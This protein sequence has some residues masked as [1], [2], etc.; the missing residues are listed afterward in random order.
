[1]ANNKDTIK[2]QEAQPIPKKIEGPGVKDDYVTREEAVVK[3]YFEEQMGWLKERI[4][5]TNYVMGVIV[6]VL[7]IG[8]ITLLITVIG[9]VIQA[10]GF[11]ANIQ[12]EMTSATKEQTQVIKA[13][14]EEI[15]K[16]EKNNTATSSA[17]PA[18]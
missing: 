13:L 4:G 14:N 12:S 5:D 2:N 16:L 18:L 15:Q 1:M 3:S 9:I 11:N 7:A 17:E 10:W 8:F 6:I